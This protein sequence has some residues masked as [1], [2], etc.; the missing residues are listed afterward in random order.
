MISVSRALGWLVRGISWRVQKLITALRQLEHYNDPRYK[1]AKID[2]GVKL[3]SAR[4][5][6]DNVI[7]RETNCIGNVVIGH[8]STFG[9][10]CIL[11]A[12]EG[13][14]EIGNYCQFA[15]NVALYAV[16]HPIDHLTTYVNQNLFGGKLQK[17]MVNGSIVVG[18][19]VWVGHG[20]I[21]LQG[22]TVGNGAII[23]AGAV[24]TKD[25]PPY[26]VVGGNPARVLK[27]RFDP[28][29]IDLLQRFQWWNLSPQQLE[30][31]QDL[32]EINLEADVERTVALL[33]QY[34]QKAAQ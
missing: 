8:H 7:G 31:Y 1:I 2:H 33:L 14:I 16:N 30:F 11:W 28:Q 23:A 17:N 10:K 22:V 32:F 12:G 18:H 4:L 27:S 13:H 20:A 34:V 6:G 29:I 21:I 25:V 24:V 15:P 5:K 9:Q 3:G 26:S 19:D